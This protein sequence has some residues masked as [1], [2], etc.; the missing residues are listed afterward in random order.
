MARWS[1][2]GASWSALGGG[3]GG[4]PIFDQVNALAV[5][6]GALVVAGSFP[7]AT[8]TISRTVN[9]IARWDGATWSP[10]G[11][12]S[13]N[14]TTPEQIAR[15]EESH[16]GQFLAEILGEGRAARMAG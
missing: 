9:N 16:T 11:S 1:I 7:T 4:D 14:G 10:L 15:V 6:A 12:A 2:S 5:E 3:V 8:D 13:S